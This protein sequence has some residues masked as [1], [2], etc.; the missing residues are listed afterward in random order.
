MV[1]EARHYLSAIGA[2]GIFAIVVEHCNRCSARHATNPLRRA[3]ALMLANLIS[4]DSTTLA[5]ECK[6]EEFAW[7]IL[8]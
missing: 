2:R 7:H 6:R 5:A 3:P 4:H 8:F 1:Y